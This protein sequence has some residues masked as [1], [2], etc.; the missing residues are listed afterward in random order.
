MLSESVKHVVQETNASVDIDNLTFASLAGMGLDVVEQTGVS[1]GGEVAA[2]EVDGKL[3]L[4]FV[5]IAR[6]RSPA[7]FG[8][9]SHCAS[10]ECMASV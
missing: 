3:D 10:I 6:K 4:G 2:I 1:L 8:F 9:R 7:G 5:G